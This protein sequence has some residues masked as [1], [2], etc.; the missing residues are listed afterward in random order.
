MIHSDLNMI[1]TIQILIQL[2]TVK[3][4]FPATRALFVI[5]ITCVKKYTGSFQNNAIMNFFY[6]KL[7][8]AFN[9]NFWQKN[10]DLYSKLIHQLRTELS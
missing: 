4:K 3:I 7:G 9:D 5:P 10:E 6:T 1:Y 8:N 2:F